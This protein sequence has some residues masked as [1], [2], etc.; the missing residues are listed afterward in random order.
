VFFS[1]APGCNKT[2][3]LR[4]ARTKNLWLIERHPGCLTCGGKED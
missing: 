1:E 2:M 4:K 3:V